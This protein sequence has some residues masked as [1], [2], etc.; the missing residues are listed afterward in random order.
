MENQSN[1]LFRCLV[2]II[3]FHAYDQVWK[4]YSL[5][6]VNSFKGVVLTYKSDKS[7]LSLSMSLNRI[8]LTHLV[9]SSFSTFKLNK[10]LL[11]I[12]GNKS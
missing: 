5:N 4:M 11:K 6:G 7:E 10:V 2:W 1:F 9:I 8:I 12:K 3:F